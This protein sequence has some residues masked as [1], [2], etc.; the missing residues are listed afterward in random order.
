[1]LSKINHWQ[2]IAINAAEQSQR[3]F[4]PEIRDISKFETII[5]AIDK[6]DLAIMPALEEKTIQI[7]DTISPF[8]GKN[9]I[10]FI[11]PEGDF[12]KE[13]VKLAKANAV[14]LVTLGHRVLKVDTA[15]IYAISVLNYFLKTK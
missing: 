3:S 13:E 12:T 1:M 9:V 6:Y 7:K 5:S 14:K 15:A 10:V 11:G 4:I 2:Q 8:K